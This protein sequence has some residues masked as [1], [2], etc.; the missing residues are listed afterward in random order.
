[1]TRAHERLRLIAARDSR[2][3]T[4]RPVVLAGAL[5]G[6]AGLTRS[7]AVWPDASAPMVAV[8][9]ADRRAALWLDRTFPWQARAPGPLDARTWQAL[10]A[11]SLIV[12]PGR[13]PAV[14]AAERAL[15]RALDQPRVALFSPSRG[16]GKLACFVFERGGAEP[17]AVVKAMADAGEGAWLEREVRFVER[18][19]GRLGGDPVADALPVAPLLAGAHEDDWLVVEPLDQLAAAAARPADGLALGWLRSFQERT[20]VARRPWS[21]DDERAELDA[22]AA[23]W[24]AL[25]PAALVPL[26]A[27]VREALGTV[28][29]CEL[30]CCAVHGDYWRGNLA[31]RDGELRVF[32]WEWGIEQGEPF[33]DRW[34]LELGELRDGL[35]AEQALG[36]AL[37][38]ALERMRAGLAEVALDPRFARATLAPAVARLAHRRRATSGTLSGW[39]ALALPL[40]RAV[41]RL[42][43]SDRDPVRAAAQV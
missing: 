15:G 2:V 39:G 11:R 30:P 1:M 19:R 33:T 41:E 12:A 36:P 38:A 20:G 28:R 16:R 9:P 35:I 21:E 43:L 31:V 10:R 13:P 18:L 8:A 37:A 3:L 32:D 6:R 22:V 24:G 7:I 42:L 29:G 14:T 34:G 26:R 5:L 25:R 23:A 27:A 40:M 4:A 17:V